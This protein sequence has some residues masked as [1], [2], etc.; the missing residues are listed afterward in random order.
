MKLTKTKTKTPIIIFLL[1]VL[2]LSC[3]STLIHL[4]TEVWW[5]D[6]V[7]FT[8]VFWTRLTCQVSIWVVTLIVYFLVLWGNYRLAM[9]AKPASR[10]RLVVNGSWEVYSRKFIDYSALI[11]IGLVAL[12]AAIASI[13]A[14]ETVLKYLN[15]SDF[16]SSEP[17][18]NRDIGF[19]VF[20]LPF[21]ESLHYWLWGLVI[22]AAIVSILAYG[23]NGAI[24]SNRR[25][26]TGM[27]LNQL[28]KVHLSLIS[29]AI[30]L[31]VAWGFWLAR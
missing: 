22:S 27:S 18:F 30:A 10:L 21:Y 5:F 13:N 2:G 9:K 3:S 28:A 11:L 7:G 15:S 20:R 25:A 1:V 31:L 12:M 26:K 6:T 24:A 16:A 23:F 14:W 8:R 19:Y 17:I 29:V 4:V